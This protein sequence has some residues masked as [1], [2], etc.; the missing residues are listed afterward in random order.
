MLFPRLCLD[1]LD[2][3]P[4]LIESEIYYELAYWALT[5]IKPHPL[6]LWY[7]V[8]CFWFS[9]FY[10]LFPIQYC[11]SYLLISWCYVTQRWFWNFDDFRIQVNYV[12]LLSPEIERRKAWLLDHEGSIGPTDTNFKDFNEFKEK[13]ADQLVRLKIDITV[14][15]SWN[16]SCLY[17]F[18]HSHKPSITSPQFSL[19]IAAVTYTIRW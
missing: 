9:Y 3:I 18:R 17:K 12:L 8:S 10:F 5:Q 2:C 15:Q 11:R 14:Y 19:V 4:N 16:I 13:Y 6:F 1:K 7:F